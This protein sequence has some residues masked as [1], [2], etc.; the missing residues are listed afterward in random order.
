MNSLIVC[1]PRSVTSEDV[2]DQLSESGM[3]VEFR[4]N[5]VTV[6]SGGSIAWIGRDSDG[7]LEREYEPDELALVSG[8]IGEWVGFIIDYRTI[9]VAVMVVAA[10]CDRWPCVIDNDDD[11]IGWGREYLDR[12]RSTESGPLTW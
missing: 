8:L 6:S 11:F 12:L 5:R 10:M 7:E 3:Q 1:V 2:R 9:E 4:D